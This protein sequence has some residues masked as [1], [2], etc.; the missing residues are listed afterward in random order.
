MK[1][2]HVKCIVCGSG[3]TVF[4]G[5]RMSPN[6]DAH[7][8]TSIVRCS[9]CGLFFPNPMPS[10][11]NK[12]IQNNFDNPAS[13]FNKGAEARLEIFE[14]PL[15]ELEKIKPEKGSLLDVGCGRGEFL[16][17]AGKRHWK[18]TGTDISDSFVRYAH[19]K[20]N[21][22]ALS[23]DLKAIDLPRESFDAATLISVI[24]YLQDPMETLKKI[25]SLLKKEGVL[26]IETT[27]EDALVFVAGDFL[28]SVRQG[29]PVTTHLSPLFPSYQ[30]Y[31]FNSKSLS[32]ALR[33]TG[34]EISHIRVEGMYGG[35]RAG[36]RG[37]GN[38]MLNLMRKI[39]IFIG[40]L[41]GRGHLIFCVAKKKET[42]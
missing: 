16:Y 32:T 42:I 14:N 17:V 36:G 10:F 30:L 37:M 5:K 22:N 34:F 3:K 19:E 41:A 6:R 8:E 35:G 2:E 38:S 29:Q 40:G 33:L 21:V 26:Y 11:E 4:L 31:G 1:F 13:Y 24:Q 7:L 20:F 28:Q 15:R 23:G 12:D 25:H 27:N 18:A 39:V 9:S